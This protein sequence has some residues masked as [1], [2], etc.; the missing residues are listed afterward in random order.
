[1]QNVRKLGALFVLLALLGLALSCG[2]EEKTT[3]TPP[4]PAALEIHD[5]TW[6]P[7]SPQPGDSITLM[8]Y[9]RNSGGTDS[10]GTG[11]RLTWNGSVLVTD[12]FTPG[13]EKGR[14][15][16]LTYRLGPRLPGSHLVEACID[17][18]GLVAEDDKGDNCLTKTLIVQS[19]GGLPNL[20]V[21]R[22]GLFPTQPMTGETVQARIVIRN[23]GHF[24]A[25]ASRTHL[26][27]DQR[28]P[29][30]TL[31]TPPLAAGAEAVVIAT[32]GALAAGG[33]TLQ[34][35][36]NVSGEVEEES[37][38]DNCRSVDF[39][40][41]P[42]TPE[43]TPDLSAIII[44]ITP[45]PAFNEDTLLVRIEI[46]NLGRAPAPATHT[47]VQVD[48]AVTCP[49]IDTPGIPAGGSVSVTCTVPPLAPGWHPVRACAD[50]ANTA[51]ESNENDNC[52]SG[53][54]SV[55]RRLLP[56]LRVESLSF[57]PE[58]P[59]KGETVVVSA[60]V[61]NRGEGIAGP[62]RLRVQL[63][64]VDVCAEVATPE[65]LPSGSATV[66]CSLGPL[67][68]GEHRVA[69]C[70]DITEREREAN[71]LDNCLGVLITVT[72]PDDVPNLVADRVTFVPE[73]PQPGDRVMADV[74]VRNTGLQAAASTL[75][76]VRLNGGTTCEG[77]STPPVPVGGEV[78]ARCDLGILNAGGRYNLEV[79]VDQDGQ[80]IESD[81]R[82]NCLVTSVN[83]PGPDVKVL[84]VTLSPRN[85]RETDPVRVTA[86]IQ[87]I[88]TATALPTTA[89]VSVSGVTACVAL[90]VPALEPGA[91]ATI[92]CDTGTWPVGW[93]S[94]DVQAD[95]TGILNE[96]DEGNNSSSASVYVA[97]TPKPDLYVNNVSV[98][99][100][101]PRVG[102]RV[103]FTVWINNGGEASAPESATRLA[104]DGQAVCPSIPVSGIPGGGFTIVRCE[105]DSLPEGDHLVEVCVDAGE[106]VTESNEGNNCQ[107]LSLPVRPRWES[108]LIVG[109]IRWT[110]S[111]PS[112]G[113]PILVMVSVKN[114]G[115][116]PAPASVTHVE[117]SPAGTSWSVDTPPIPAGE[118]V[119]V[120]HQVDS[121]NA[122]WFAILVTVDWTAVVAEG[123]EGNNLGSG[124]LTV[125]PSPAPDLRIDPSWISFNPADPAPTDSVWIHVGFPNYG[126]LTAPASHTQILV[127]GEVRFAGIETPSIPAGQ[128]GSVDSNMGILTP[129]WHWIEVR[130]DVLKEIAESDESNN[131]AFRELLVRG[132]AGEKA[133]PKP[134]I[135][136]SIR[137]RLEARGRAASP[138]RN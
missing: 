33:H 42:P 38:V 22:I 61:S 20:T 27:V 55:N 4:P 94:F 45:N 110:P 73:N 17:P 57:V 28:Q 104:I 128:W 6:T 133:F 82:D 78:V 24:A 109:E 132:P 134:P 50:A 91:A 126:G 59:L 74:H 105:V 136:E 117:M 65:I 118:S 123:N 26:I 113:N 40:V 44:G 119:V 88:G 116:R 15:N 52:A 48:G 36:A 11:T 97:T 10:P 124:Y 58:H 90:D 30:D 84:S 121:L 13:I 25:A 43:P 70:A 92:N 108:D 115:T 96:V 135:P 8:V 100:S 46:R 79:C 68:P 1:M 111:N 77:I 106:Q 64:G 89:R 102:Q 9:I 98:E 3:E 47:D 83:V 75:T 67:M 35:C 114:I 76:R 16:V 130:L 60:L 18:N 23:V 5:I 32:L 49:G 85:P 53:G 131:W 101:T 41:L 80:V 31:A 122:G 2:D 37:G 14:S 51:L 12:L 93:Q 19:R 7:L 71:E 99:P 29:A 87:N 56:N 107:S 34:A 21:D 81:E 120:T 72:D 39:L 62:T 125:G 69:A 127:D 66:S 54:I 129:G 86:V 138:G 103:V 63:D 137:T 95:V 112:Q